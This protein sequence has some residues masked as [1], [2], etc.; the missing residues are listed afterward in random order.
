MKTRFVLCA[1][2]LFPAIG[3]GMGVTVLREDLIDPSVPL[4][5][6]G[7]G[8]SW[9]FAS[10]MVVRQDD[11]VWFSLS[12]PVERVPP[13]A[14]TI[15]QVYRRTGEGWEVI[16]ESPGPMDREP[17]PLVGLNAYTLAVFANPKVSFNR[18]RPENSAILWNSRP[19]L[20][21]FP[22]AMET[23]ET[24][25]IEPVFSGDPVLRE[26]TYRAI[27]V[28][29]AN[30]EVFVM[31]Q[32]PDSELYHPSYLDP[33]GQWHALPAFSFPKRGLYANAQM[34][35][36]RVHL[37]AVSDIQEPVPEWRAAKFRKFDRHWDYAYRNLYYT[38]SPNVLEG[39]FGEP[40]VVDS[41]EERPGH[42]RNLDLLVDAGG[43]AHLLYL[44][45]SFQ[46][47]FLRDEFFPDE[48]MRVVI[49]YA[50]IKEGAIQIRTD[51]IEGLMEPDEPSSGMEG[52]LTWARLHQLLDGTIVMIYTERV[53]GRNRTG[54]LSIGPDGLPGDQVEIDLQH[55]M[56]SVFFTNTE[57][58]GSLPSNRID[59][60]EMTWE[61]T[62]HEVRY[63]EIEVNP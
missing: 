13:Y 35:D 40:L 37:A 28:N 63:A 16:L 24:F 21:A 2:L 11:Q 19:Q 18:F 6:N 38:W 42:I 34:R 8:P 22:S 4:F 43:T 62:H 59:L 14:N 41:I 50:Q 30:S 56:G 47:G 9:N 49:G 36:G 46:Y 33:I 44:K 55:P 60:L 27:A 53:A 10:P 54:L 20:L 15:W 31:V 26:H 25:L 58:G 39:G 48:P 51:L 45:K 12:R 57:R 23:P 61:K 29:P 5:G 7:S 3:F 32:D 1:L 52:E 17:C